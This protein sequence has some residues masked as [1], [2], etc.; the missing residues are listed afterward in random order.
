MIKAMY[1]RVKIQEKSYYS[2][3]FAYYH[4]DY[5]AYSEKQY[6]KSYFEYE[7]DGFGPVFEDAEALADYVYKMAE[8][9]FKNT[10]PYISR[11]KEFF[12]LFDTNNC[13]RNYRAIK[14]KW[15]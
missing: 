2:Q 13:E 9:G 1:V 14:E 3:V 11:H 5:E 10:E 12:T 4:F 6:H 7:K 8:N 15:S